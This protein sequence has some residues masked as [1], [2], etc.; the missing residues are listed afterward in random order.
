MTKFIPYEKM[1]KKQK[2]EIDRMKRGSWHGVN[3]VTRKSENQ[4]AYNRKKTAKRI[5][6]SFC[7]LDFYI[8]SPVQKSPSATPVIRTCLISLHTLSSALT[9]TGV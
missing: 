6:D 2:K 1:S 7:G 8:S 5:D 9:L 3:P 4:K